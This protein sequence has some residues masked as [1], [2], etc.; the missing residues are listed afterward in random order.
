MLLE[1][2][3]KKKANSKFHENPSGGSR[4]VPC[5]RRDRRNYR[6][7]ASKSLFRRFAKASNNDSDASKGSK[8]GYYLR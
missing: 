1:R 2:F 7:D 4:V 5:V 6:L 3:K 8:Y